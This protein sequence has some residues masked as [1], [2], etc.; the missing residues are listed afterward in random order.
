MSYQKTFNEVKAV[1]WNEATVSFYI[2]KRKLIN[3][4]A[5]YNVFHVNIAEQYA[6]EKKHKLLQN[7]NNSYIIIKN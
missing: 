2:V 4:K 1:N 6:K 3:R 5:E 7:Y